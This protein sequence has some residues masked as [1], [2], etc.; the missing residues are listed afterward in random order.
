MAAEVLI[1]KEICD[2]NKS[3]TEHLE[4]NNTII[5]RLCGNL[6]GNFMIK[7]FIYNKCVALIIALIIIYV[8]VMVIVDKFTDNTLQD[9]MVIHLLLILVMIIYCVFLALT[10]NVKCLKLLC[11]HFEFWIKI[12]ICVKL[13]ICNIIMNGNDGSHDEIGKL[14]LIQITLFL[15]ILN[16]SVMD[17]LQIPSFIKI[18]I[19]LLVAI[20]SSIYALYFFIKIEDNN[21][22]KYKTIPIINCQI[23]M[24]SVISSSWGVISMFVWKQTVI[25]IYNASKC[26]DRAT[27]INQPVYLQ[28]ST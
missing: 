20:Y 8:I 16:F 13:C 4:P 17:A 5:H 15:F 11:Q 12:G 2:R 28:W 22:I 1:V 7:Y 6:F 23:N 19:G 26:Q 3:V 27:I 9:C 25:S 18:M 14:I 24:I 10:A 21:N